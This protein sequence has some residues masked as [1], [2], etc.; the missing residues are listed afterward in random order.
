MGLENIKLNS[1]DRYKLKH[2]IKELKKPQHM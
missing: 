2:F 1:K